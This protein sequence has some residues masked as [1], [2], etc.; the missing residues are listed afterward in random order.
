MNK[1]LIFDICGNKVILSQNKNIQIVYEKECFDKFILIWF[2]F[3]IISFGWRLFFWG[4]NLLNF[5]FYNLEGM[6]L[7]FHGN[8]IYH[9]IDNSMNLILNFLLKLWYCTHYQVWIS[10]NLI[11]HIRYKHFQHILIEFQIYAFHSLFH[12]IL[13][14]IGMSYD[15]LY[16]HYIFWN[17]C[18]STKF[19]IVR[20]F[21]NKH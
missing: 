7:M 9:L 16:N 6:L 19:I 14:R 21:N 4:W 13:T 2:L 18:I 8:C 5:H 12:L 15:L 1:E 11:Y 10:M 17:C 3:W 20:I